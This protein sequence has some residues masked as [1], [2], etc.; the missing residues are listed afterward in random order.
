MRPMTVDNIDRLLDELPSVVTVDEVAEL[1]RYHPVTIGR[2]LETGFLPGSKLGKEWR[3]LRED[4]RQLLRSNSNSARMA[5]RE[6]EPSPP[7]KS[8]EGGE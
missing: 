6:A 2:W 5:E 4:V 8:S 7:T 3:I 1:L